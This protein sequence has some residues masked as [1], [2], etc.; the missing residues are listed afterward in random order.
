MEKWERYDVMFEVYREVLRRLPGFMWS[1]DMGVEL[2][3]NKLL[4]PSGWKGKVMGLE[5]GV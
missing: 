1:K 3:R 4:I 5:E 2:E